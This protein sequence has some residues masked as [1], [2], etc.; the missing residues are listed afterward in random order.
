MCR[1]CSSY[2][3]GKLSPEEAL[4]ELE[5]ISD[6]ISNNHY[7]EIYEMLINVIAKNTQLSDDEDLT[8]MYDGLDFTDEDVEDWEENE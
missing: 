7:D 6:I 4:L 5:N 8:D 3:K 1:V 2:K